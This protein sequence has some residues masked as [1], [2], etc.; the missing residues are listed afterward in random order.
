MTVLLYVLGVLFVALGV[1]LSIG[2][3]E[4]GHLLPAKKFGVKVTQYMVGFGPTVWST[5]RGET[6]YGIK[7]IPL[8]GYIRMIGMFPPR[9]GD[10]PGTLRVSSTGR[11]SQLADE[12][13][14]LS[15]EEI[16]PG[17]EDRVF[18]KLSVP[19]KVVVMMGGPVMNLVIA[20][21]L[22]T[23]LV[24]LYGQEV[25]KDGA[26][27]AS[28]S[29]C[30]V[31]ASQATAKTTCAPSDPKTPAYR[32]GLRPGDRIVSIAGQP[33]KRT[34][35]VGRLIRPRVGQPTEIVVLR[36][37]ARQTLEVSPI[38]NTVQQVGPN[39]APLVDASG[40]PVVVTAGFLG[41]SSAPVQALERQPVTVVPGILGQ[42]I[43]HIAGVLVHIPQ[44][45]TDVAE[46][47]F[48]S[49]ARDPN[50]PMSVVG[51]GRMAGEIS[52]GSIQGVDESL[53]GKL[54][55]LVSLMAGLNLALFVFNLIPLLPLDGGH[56][57]GALWEGLKRNAARLLNR[58]D[59]G[60]VDV[61]KALPIAYAVST[62]LIVMSALLIYADFV[63][64]VKL[65]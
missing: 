17:D 47:A 1:G 42:Q 56:V 2:L 49:K 52:S 38:R 16:K 53:A 19:K 45:M 5:R 50:G 57:A 48:G 31:P 24:T 8:G 62:V 9:P 12:A 6:E 33:I 26:L 51:V 3:H 58:P 34:T 35:D 27:V 64:P 63:K 13:R 60:H 11:F 23:G 46:A 36:G 28:V 40:H 15:L 41:V 32:A 43:S 44:R 7:A 55:I 59:P 65:G 37:G 10:K 14:Q 21:V 20:V 61:A 30:V 18:Y 22:L 29:E 54:A 39:G 25:Q 4:I